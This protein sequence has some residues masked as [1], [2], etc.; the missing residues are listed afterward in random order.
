MK[1]FQVANLETVSKFLESNGFK[2]IDIHTANIWKRDNL[3]VAEMQGLW[4]LKSEKEKTFF[5]PTPLKDIKK[6]ASK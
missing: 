1:G 2:K 3:E 6:F 5:Q 4:S